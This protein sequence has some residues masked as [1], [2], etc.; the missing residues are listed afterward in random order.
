MSTTA[1]ELDVVNA[2]PVSLSEDLTNS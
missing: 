2:L 1:L